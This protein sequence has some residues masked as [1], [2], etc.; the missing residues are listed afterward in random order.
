MNNRGEVVI[1]VNGRRVPRCGHRM[2]AEGLVEIT[3]I[4]E[5]I[6]WVMCRIPGRG[7]TSVVGPAGKFYGDERR[8]ITFDYE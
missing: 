2:T 1:R 7:E 6:M 5:A 4:G 3:R 8:N